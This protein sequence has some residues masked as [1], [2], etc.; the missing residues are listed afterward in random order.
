PEDLAQAILEIKNMPTEEYE[1]LGEN[2]KKGAENFDFK[3]LTEKL[4]D[5]INDVV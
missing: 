4:I 5:V 2:A 3:I 1:L